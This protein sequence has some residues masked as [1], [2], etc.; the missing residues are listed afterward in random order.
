[1][2]RS[3]ALRESVAPRKP[4][5]IGRSRCRARRSLWVSLRPSALQRRKSTSEIEPI[6]SICGRFRMSSLSGKDGPTYSARGRRVATYETISV[7]KLTPIIGAEINGIDLAIPLSNRTVDE[8]HR[9]DCRRHCFNKLRRLDCRQW[10]SDQTGQ[11]CA[12]ARRR[13]RLFRWNAASTGNVGGQ[14]GGG[15][16]HRSRRLRRQYHRHARRR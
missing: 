5:P 13:Q 10:C 4:Q 3:G 8:I 6:C 16:G 15:A 9:A 1:M 2:P 14:L 12:H 11:R 7:D